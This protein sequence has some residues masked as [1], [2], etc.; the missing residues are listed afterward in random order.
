MKINNRSTIDKIPRVVLFQ[1]RTEVIKLRW[2]YRVQLIQ[3]RPGL[4]RRIIAHPLVELI[5]SQPFKRRFEPWLQPIDIT[6]RQPSIGHVQHFVRCRDLFYAIEF[7]ILHIVDKYPVSQRHVAAE[8]R[9]GALTALTRCV[10][11]IGVDHPRVTGIEVEL[12]LLGHATTT[13][14]LCYWLTHGE[15]LH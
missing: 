11:F 3:S 2:Q 1:L 13:G 9:I 12:A 14:E 8:D 6:L 15:Q 7:G 5:S 4:R 10:K